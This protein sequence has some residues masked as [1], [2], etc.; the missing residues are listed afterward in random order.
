MGLPHLDQLLMENSALRSRA[1]FY[2]RANFNKSVKVI[3]GHNLNKTFL[4]TSLFLTND[5]ALTDY[6]RSAMP[7]LIDAAIFYLQNMPYRPILMAVF[8]YVNDMTRASLIIAES[9]FTLQHMILGS[10][11]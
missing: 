10:R 5:T 1:C 11:L 4:F 6:M 2:S 8:G 9:T 7:S 3:V